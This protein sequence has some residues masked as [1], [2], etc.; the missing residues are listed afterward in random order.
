M[1]AAVA[2]A[3]F[4]ALLLFGLVMLGA[5]APGDTYSFW[6]VG[7]TGLMAAGCVFLFYCLAFTKPRAASARANR[8]VWTAFAGMAT[9]AFLVSLIWPA[10]RAASP[11]FGM[12]AA[13]AISRATLAWSVSRASKDRD[14]QH[15]AV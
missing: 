8:F 11:M 13:I 1:L 14:G 12:L 5:S 3:V 15:G 10:P 4:L 2:S 6:F 9:V 7:V